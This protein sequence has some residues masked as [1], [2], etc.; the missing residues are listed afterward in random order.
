MYTMLNLLMTGGATS[1]W[2]QFIPLILI[3]VVFYFFMIR[4]QV[5]KQK[6]AKKFMENIKKG[7]KVVTIGG[8]H[9]KIHEVQEGAFIVEIA[10]GVRVKVLKTALSMD[11]SVALNQNQN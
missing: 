8:I 1:G 9:G 2:G 3:V 5:K 10:D 4:P 11:G 7:D 6:E